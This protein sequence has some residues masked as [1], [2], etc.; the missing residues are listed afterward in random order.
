MMQGYGG[1][2]TAHLTPVPHARCGKHPRLLV[3]RIRSH[4][5]AQPLNSNRH[6]LQAK[7]ARKMSRATSVDIVHDYLGN[8]RLGAWRIDV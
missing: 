5:V 8:L 4:N 3:V 6:F 7:S 2:L 1:K